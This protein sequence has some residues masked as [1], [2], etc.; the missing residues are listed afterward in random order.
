MARAGQRLANPL[1][2]NEPT[3]DE[4]NI[5]AALASAASRNQSL[6]RRQFNKLM[7]Y[8]EQIRELRSQDASFVTIE[9]I[10][11]ANSFRVS[12]ETIRVFYREVIEQKRPKRKQRQR[13]ADDKKHS[14]KLK[15][16]RPK[17]WCIGEPRIARIEDL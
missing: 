7:G 6:R 15:P 9:K 13:K 16:A 2:M 1:N 5:R 10:L 14:A 11:R 3:Q 8:K 12:H 4:E 17:T